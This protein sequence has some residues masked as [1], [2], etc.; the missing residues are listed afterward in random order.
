MQL[1]DLI[2]ISGSGQT[3]NRYGDEQNSPNFEYCSSGIYSTMNPNTLGN[4]QFAL[5]TNPE[6]SLLL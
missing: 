1:K 6:K 5:F 3:A 2:V 4:I